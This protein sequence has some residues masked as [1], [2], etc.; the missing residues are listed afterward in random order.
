MYRE[1]LLIGAENNDAVLWIF[2]LSGAANENLDSYPPHSKLVTGEN[3]F[4]VKRGVG[5]GFN[6]MKSLCRGLLHYK[7]VY[8]NVIYSYTMY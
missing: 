6:I 2:R 3:H 4:L 5:I 1:S 7:G 8:C